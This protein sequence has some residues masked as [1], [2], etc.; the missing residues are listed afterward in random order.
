[1][2]IS[3]NKQKGSAVK[4]S[5][6][7]FRFTDG[8]NV[9]RIVGDILARYVYWVEGE[10]NKQIP[11][12]CLAFNRDTET[13]DNK[14]KDWVKAYYPDLKCG[15]SYATQCVLPDGRVQVV[16]LK[17][18]LWEQV[19]VVAEDLGDPTDPET[20]WDIC[21]KRVKT[22]P[23]AYNVEYT[24]QALK[25]QKSVRPLTEVELEGIKDLKSM[26]E[27]MPR[28]TPD[29]QKEFLDRIRD[30]AASVTEDGTDEEV[31]EDE[32]NIK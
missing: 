10:N 13:F 31:I 25:C 22:G 11:V 4:S 6:D 21:F 3:F 8:D 26:D 5:I 7:T 32:F 14:E 27:V 29:S 18:K 16:N 17:K 15:W 19:M 30:A 2:A 20:G 24:L 9:M 28:P 1:M 12:E 23:M